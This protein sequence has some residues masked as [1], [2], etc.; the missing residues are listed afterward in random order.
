MSAD[1]QE[2]RKS[3]R[4]QFSEAMLAENEMFR[5]LRRETA[6]HLERATEADL[7]EFERALCGS[8][9]SDLPF[10][11]ILRRDLAAIE[12]KLDELGLPPPR[13]WVLVMNGEWGPLPEEGNQEILKEFGPMMELIDARAPYRI[14]TG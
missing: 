8:D 5:V 10:A 1:E 2:K 6:L 14:E 4:L 3:R 11:E 7:E 13:G 9:A 12:K